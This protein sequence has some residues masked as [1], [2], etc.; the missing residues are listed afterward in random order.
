MTMPE[1]TVELDSWVKT[2]VFDLCERER[3]PAT[4]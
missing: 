1:E 4:C 2:I 3:R